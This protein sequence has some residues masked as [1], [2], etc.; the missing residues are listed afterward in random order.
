MPCM[1]AG[2]CEPFGAIDILW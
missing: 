2:F 1:L